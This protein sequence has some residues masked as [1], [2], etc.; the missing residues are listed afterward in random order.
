MV[1]TV[2]SVEISANQ[3]EFLK[4]ER[5][6]FISANTGRVSQALRFA[7]ADDSSEGQVYA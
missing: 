3:R 6:K 7:I 1:S 4:A 2:D 5:G